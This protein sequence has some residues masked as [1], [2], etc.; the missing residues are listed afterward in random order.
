MP[1]LPLVSIVSPSLNQAQFLEQAIHSVLGQDYQR[2]EYIIVDGGSTDG[3]AEI[4]RR[5][6]DRLAWWV[7]ELDTGQ[8]EAIN[9]GLRRARGEIVAWLNSDDVYLPGAVAEAVRAFQ[10]YP[11]AGLVFGN[12]LAIDEAGR[13]LNLLRYG[14]WNLTDLMA[15]RIIGQP[16]V[17]LRR[18]ALEQAGSLDTSYHYL[19]D[20]QLWLRMAQVSGLRY[21][22]KT[23]AAARYHLAA[24]N[25]AHPMEFAQEV[26]RIASW[27][28]SQPAL[29]DLLAK[30]RKYIQAGRHTL[31]AFYL[32]EDGESR[33][34]MEE[35]KRA[36]AAH[37]PTVLRAWKRVAYAMLNLLG[38][39]RLR[40]VY[41]AARRQKA[42]I[43]KDTK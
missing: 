36:F 37:P 31:S 38:L 11:E 4:I 15:F 17:F 6:A 20:H 28:E 41:L 13:T 33:L 32:V 14:D 30:N 12:V 27:M 19:L 26:Q 22:P 8:A 1:N 25:I 35:Y 21:L 10:A 34:A 39:G 43:M 16:A 40:R 29:A 3:S 18:S 7:S 9:K 23:L 2:L 5:Y 24:K 42:L